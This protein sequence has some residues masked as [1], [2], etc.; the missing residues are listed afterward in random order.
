MV[1]SKECNWLIPM[2]KFVARNLFYYLQYDSER[3]VVHLF[4]AECEALHNS[5]LSSQDGDDDKLAKMV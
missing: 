5:Q 4:I 1:A 3:I 2:G